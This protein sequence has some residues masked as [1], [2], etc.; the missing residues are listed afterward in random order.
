MINQN[1]TLIYSLN[2]EQKNY[3][4]VGKLSIIVLFVIFLY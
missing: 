4:P 1:Y 3:L 2:K